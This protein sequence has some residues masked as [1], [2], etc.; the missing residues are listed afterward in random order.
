LIY[1]DKFYDGL[2]FTSI[3]SK[4]QILKFLKHHYVDGKWIERE[5]DAEGRYI[6]SWNYHLGVMKIF[7]RWLTN[8]D[9]PNDDW[10]TP[11]FVK[12]KLKKPLRD[13]PYD[14]NNIWE[15]DE[16]LTIISY[17]PELRNQAIITL[18]WDLDARNHEITAL[19]IKDI[20]LREQYGEGI[21]PSNTKT[22]GGPILLTSS[23]T[24]VRDWINKHPF[25]NE[26]NAKLICSLIN[27]TSLNAQTIWEVLKQLKLRI[28]RLV[29][30]GSITDGQRK[31]KLEHLLRT[32]KWNP[33]CF[34]HSA[35]TKDSDQLPE[36]VVKKKARWSMN[37][38]QGKRYIKRSWG[39]DLK[40]NMLERQGIKIVNKQPQMVSRTCA[41]CS[42]VNKLESKFCEGKGCNYPLTQLAFDE[43]KAAEQ[44]KFQELINKSNLERDNTIQALQQELKSKT[45]EMQSLSELCK[46]SLELSSKQNGT[47][48]DYK[49]MVD[50]VNSRYDELMGLYENLKSKFDTS[51]SI[52]KT[53]FERIDELQS[54]MRGGLLIKPGRR[55]AE[56]LDRRVKII[57]QVVPDWEERGASG[58]VRLTSE[59]ERKVMELIQQPK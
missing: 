58:I 46:H 59:E 54:D 5:C 36:Y 10:E 37:S 57:L 32:K 12:I 22:G 9:I 13:S 7:F 26:P 51:V 17:E 39:E 40:N 20:V 25:K 14:I 52:S 42:Y 53:A 35:I 6:T 15:L 2:P 31:Q 28:K 48:S 8:R 1:F 24:Y 47:I 34:R 55:T 45:Q 16:V 27:G 19:R 41:R 18:L 4:E 29:E 56:E 49:G 3:D 38:Q 43:I 11:S 50:D 44:A 33:Y 21:I 30:S 23:F